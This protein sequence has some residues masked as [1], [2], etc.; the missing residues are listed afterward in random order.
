MHRPHAWTTLQIEPRAADTL[1]NVT[2]GVLDVD[3][4]GS[5]AMS[6][7]QRVSARKLESLIEKVEGDRGCRPF[8][9]VAVSPPFAPLGLD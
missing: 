2:L 6:L 8:L 9:L 3:S 1:N 4:R 7:E 5:G